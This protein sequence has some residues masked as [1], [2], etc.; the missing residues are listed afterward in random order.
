MGDERVVS[1]EQGEGQVGKQ[2]E[3]GVPADVAVTESAEAFA[4]VEGLRSEVGG[5]ADV[6]AALEALHPAEFADEF[7]QLSPEARAG[8]IAMLPE[9]MTP[10]VLAELETDVVEDVLPLL[11]TETLVDALGELDNDDA[12]Q[13]V[14]EMEDAQ[15][16]EVLG[17]LAPESRA[18]LIDALSFDEDEVGRLMQRAF[19]AAPLD[20]TVGDAIDHMRGKGEDL[21]DIFFNI[22]IV[23]EGVKPQGYVPLSALMREGRGVRLADIMERRLVPIGDHMDKEEAAFLFERYDLISAPVVNG[24]GVLVGMMTVDDIIDIIQDENAE[25]MLALAGVREATASD[26]VGEVVRARAPWLALNLLT[27]ILASLVIAQFEEAIAQIVAL[28]VL[29]PIVASMGGNAGTQAL[30]VAVRQLS[31]RG[32]T[33]KT[34]WRSVRREAGAAVVI[35]LF[36]AVAMAGIAWVWFGRGDLAGVVFVAMVVNHLFAGVAGIAVPLGLKRVGADPAVASSV[37]VTTV[38][39]VVGFFAFL[40][41]AAWWLL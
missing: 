14:E 12:T 33:S 11:S 35:G 22:Y 15:R 26:T 2:E 4:A 25:D 23:D 3:G 18:E 28:A 41:L 19:V 36:F 30:T 10:D 13:I 9:V 40:G 8:L 32:L 29:M 21:P 6:R 1:R 16:A 27:A 31:E 38:T 17:A 37:F 5:A 24:E 39:D 7:E 34:A 20:W